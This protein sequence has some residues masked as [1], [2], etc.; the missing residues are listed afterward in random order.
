MLYLLLGEL[1]LER[2]FLLGPG[3]FGNFPVMACC[4]YLGKD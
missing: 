2:M 4:L 3:V 1:A